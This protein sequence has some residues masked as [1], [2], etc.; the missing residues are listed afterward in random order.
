[1]RVLLAREIETIRVGTLA[2]TP[3]DPSLSPHCLNKLGERLRAT[4]AL[5]EPLP[6]RLRELVDRLGR[7]ELRDR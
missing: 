2:E 7:R 5:P 3:T 4:Y 1:M 6:V